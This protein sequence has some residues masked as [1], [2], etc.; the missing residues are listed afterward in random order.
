M[1]CDLYVVCSCFICSYS[2][3]QLSLFTNYGLLLSSL[4]HCVLLLPSLID[5]AQCVG[6]DSSILSGHCK[7]PCRWYDVANG[8]RKKMFVQWI[9]STLPAHTPSLPVRTHS[10]APSSSKAPVKVMVDAS[11]CGA[12]QQGV[13]TSDGE[14]RCG[15]GGGGGGAKK[16][17]GVKK[18]KE[19]LAAETPQRWAQ[20]CGIR[21]SALCYAPALLPL[22]HPH[23]HPYD[24]CSALVEL[25]RWL[26]PTNIPP[27]KK[28]M[29]IPTRILSLCEAEAFTSR[30]CVLEQRCHSLPEPHPPTPQTA[31]ESTH[32]AQLSSVDHG[33]V[34]E[35]LVPGLDYT[36]P[37]ETQSSKSNL[38]RWVS[39]GN[40]FIVGVAWG[41]RRCCGSSGLFYFLCVTEQP[42][43]A[44]SGED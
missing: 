38:C 25:E 12:A 34:P 11:G 2:H 43:S 28:Q 39:G 41:S 27:S 14:R 4:F 6:D 23:L 36:T 3:P 30:L 32:M 44:D 17:D 29:Q 16:E 33:M 8:L 18:K 9:T 24:L 21:N 20:G 10:S 22:L 40:G 37:P 1:W 42:C 31:A 19:W 5:P 15:G 13:N 7:L 35:L 26:S